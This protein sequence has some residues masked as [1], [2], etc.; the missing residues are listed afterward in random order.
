M[1]SNKSN[2]RNHEYGKVYLLSWLKKKKKKCNKH[3]DF[4]F[5]KSE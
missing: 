5:V 3:V 4:I 1:K 2:F